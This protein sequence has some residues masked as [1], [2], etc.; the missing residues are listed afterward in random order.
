MGVRF[1]SSD[2]SRHQSPKANGGGVR[3]SEYKKLL[4]AKIKASNKPRTNTDYRKPPPPPRALYFS[5]TLGKY[6]HELFNAAVK[7]NDFKNVEKQLTNLL[8]NFTADPKLQNSLISPIIRREAKLK[9]VTS[10]VSGTSAPVA[11]VIERL[12]M[13]NRIRDL[14]IFVD[15][16]T[17]LVAEKLGQVTATVFSVE[18][19][20]SSQLERIQNR[21]ANIVEPGK[22]LVLATQLNPKLLG[23]I[24]IR[25]GDRELDLSVSSKIKQFE[26]VFRSAMN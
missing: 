3:T 17:R 23:G 20:T 25:I 19:L 26:Q 13:E 12:V 18:P 15:Y 11:A 21:M 1:M 6:S 2:R 9:T 8:N 7:S 5:G 10:F 4:Q 14:K 22:T 16:F 24:K